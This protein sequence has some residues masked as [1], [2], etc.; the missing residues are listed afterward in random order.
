MLSASIE[1][2][3]TVKPIPNAS[4]VEAVPTIQS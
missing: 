3:S 1:Y 2:M 4:I